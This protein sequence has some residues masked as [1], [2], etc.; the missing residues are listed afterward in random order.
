MRRQLIHNL[1]VFFQ[2]LFRLLI[3]FMQQL[4]HFG[5][6]IRRR[7]VGT[8]QGG[9]AVQILALHR[10][11]SHQTELFAHTET[12]NHIPGNARS[13]LNIVGRACGNSVKNNLLRRPAA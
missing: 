12:G 11:K 9:P 4:H 2:K 1:S 5:I 8:G 10:G 7:H 3:A 6:N 13:L